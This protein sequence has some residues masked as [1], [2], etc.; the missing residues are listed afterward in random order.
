MLY[1]GLY[2]QIRYNPV[3]QFI[4]HI[5]VLQGSPALTVKIET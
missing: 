3:E 1:N 2:H 4:D 5:F